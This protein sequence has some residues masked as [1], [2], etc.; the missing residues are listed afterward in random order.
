[1][2]SVSENLFFEDKSL[3]R[4]DIMSDCIGSVKNLR[5]HLRSS[6]YPTGRLRLHLFSSAVK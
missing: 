6:V 2:M 4:G 3:V 1:M 5:L